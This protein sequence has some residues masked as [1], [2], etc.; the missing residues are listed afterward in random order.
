MIYAPIIIPT[1]NRAEHLRRCITSLQAN[2]WAKY[3]ELIISVDFPPS[4]KYFDGYRAVC[5][6]L[7][8]GVEGF[9]CVEIIYQETNLG[10]YQNMQFLL[11]YSMKKCDRYIFL[12]DDNE[13]SPNFIEFIDKGLEIFEHDEGIMAIC[14]VG[15]ALKGNESY[16]VVKSQNFAAYGYGMWHAKRIEMYRMLNNGFYEELARNK[17]KLLQ[18]IHTNV[19]LLF[20]LQ[21]IIFDQEKT[22]RVEDGQIPVIDQ[23]IKMYLIT[24]HKYVI[25]ACVNKARN[26]GLDGSGENCKKD[27]RYNPREIIFD[28]ND[29]FDYQYT[30]PMGM[31]KLKNEFTL[32]IRCQVLAA[33]LKI[34]VWKLRGGRIGV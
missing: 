2:P 17:D 34:W 29:R 16:N 6:Y 7:Q 31:H 22:Y 12:E 10:A 1:L 9:A 32:K 27:T 26:W 19:G 28:Q 25:G 8:S 4:Q 24:E 21:A 18:L 5:G 3:T 14:A 30:N 13:F 23:M 33:L 20:S 15:S 11:D